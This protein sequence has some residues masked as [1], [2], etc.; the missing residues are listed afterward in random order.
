L[1]LDHL[2]DFI[3]ALPAMQTL[4]DR[5]PHDDITLVC[6][7]WNQGIAERTGLFDTNLAYDFFPPDS[8][9]SDSAHLHSLS[10]FR[11]L[12]HGEY[13]IAIDLRVDS[14]TRF[15]LSHVDTTVRCGIGAEHEFPY[16]DIALPTPI[17]GRLLSDRRA[18]HAFGAASFM[19]NVLAPSPLRWETDFRRTDCCIV[20]GPYT[21]LPPGDYTAVFH[22]GASGLGLA[23]ALSRIELD[24]AHRTVPIAGLRLGRRHLRAGRATLAFSNPDEHGAIEFRVS[25]YGRPPA[26]TFWFFGVTVESASSESDRPMRQWTRLLHRGECASLLVSLLA[27]RMTVWPPSRTHLEGNTLAGALPAE[28]AQIIE[29]PGA[30]FIAPLSKASIKDWPLASYMA[31]VRMILERNQSV[32]LLGTADQRDALDTIANSGQS[33]SLRAV[34]LAGRIPWAALPLLFQGA[35]LVIAGNSGV[36][37]LAAQC[38]ARVLAIFSGTHTPEEWGPRSSGGGLTITADVPCSPCGYTDMK[39]CTYQ[40]RCMTMIS[41]E[42]VFREVSRLLELS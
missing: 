29:S 18:R 37:H 34:N 36:A 41:P 14:D 11:S 35:A 24:V 6:G 1:K 33:S 39:Q 38:G 23:G 31:L 32:V 15:L 21:T 19:S 10:D 20:F 25:T 8:S 9:R 30:I 26:G 17:R 5:F 42:R 4:R 28:A 27:E 16:L 3:I 7:S 2:G 13:D 40:H 12:T 22:I